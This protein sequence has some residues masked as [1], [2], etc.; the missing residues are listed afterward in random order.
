MPLLLL[1]AVIVMPDLLDEKEPLTD[2][3]PE[4]PLRIGHELMD[5]DW[6]L[7]V[8]VELMVLGVLELKLAPLELVPKIPLL[9]LEPKLP[10][11]EL[12]PKLSL[13]ELPMKLPLLEL[14]MKTP[15]LEL[16]P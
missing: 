9:E 11:L 6:E 12:A 13:L 7:A 2:E 8:T 15:L 14:E 10:L 1:L 3:I 4:E 16:G 5:A